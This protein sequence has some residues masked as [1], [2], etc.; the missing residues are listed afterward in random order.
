MPHEEAQLLRL[1][2]RPSGLDSTEETVVLW[3]GPRREVWEQGN[4]RI[5]IHRI[6][7]STAF[8]IVQVGNWLP[9]F[10]L[11]PLGFPTLLKKFWK[12]VMLL[13]VS[14]FTEQTTRQLFNDGD[15]FTISFQS[16][17]LNTSRWV[18][19]AL[20]IPGSRVH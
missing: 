9:R 8:G 20:L 5:S 17:A 6:S 10:R 18:G 11:L 12:Y 16:S 19:V 4:E 7:I 13:W 2:V 15:A 14:R 1:I 3:S